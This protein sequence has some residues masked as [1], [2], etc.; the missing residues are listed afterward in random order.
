MWKI[1]ELVIFLIISIH[2]CGMKDTVS[3]SSPSPV[4]IFL[5]EDKPIPNANDVQKLLETN[6]CIGCDLRG[7]DLQGRDL[8]GANLRHALLGEA[9]FDGAN[10]EKADFR[11]SKLF[12]EYILFE[13]SKPPDYDPSDEHVNFLVYNLIPATIRKVL[14]TDDNRR[15]YNFNQYYLAS[16]GVTFRGANLTEANFSKTHLRAITFRNANLT[17]IDFREARIDDKLDLINVNLTDA[18]MKGA[19]LGNGSIVLRDY[20]NNNSLIC[21]NRTIYPN[22]KYQDICTK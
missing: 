14:I 22:G 4:A 15:K 21:P 19:I 5:N 7:A 13:F 2:F 20:I 6:S 18:T 9:N 1:Q 12:N 8:R 16:V 10:L 11:E 17:R 3:A